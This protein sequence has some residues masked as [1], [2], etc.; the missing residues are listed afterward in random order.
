MPRPLI[1]E[2]PV[3]TACE[4]GRKGDCS[5][6]MKLQFTVAPAAERELPALDGGISWL[7]A[8]KLGERGWRRGSYTESA[9]ASGS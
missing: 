9:E 7:K 8:E 5:A 4:A 3:Q 1:S 6:P 2:R